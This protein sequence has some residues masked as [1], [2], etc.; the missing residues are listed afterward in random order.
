M[1]IEVRA[2]NAKGV[3]LH[4]YHAK[5]M[6]DARSYCIAQSAP[7]FV[8]GFSVEGIGIVRVVR[9]VDGHAVGFRRLVAGEFVEGGPELIA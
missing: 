7:E 4:T 5:S 2:N 9:T 1:P 8:D 6:D 3:P